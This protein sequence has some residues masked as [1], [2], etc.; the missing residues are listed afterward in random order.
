MGPNLGFGLV[1]QENTNTEKG[2]GVL[3]EAITK[4]VM[5]SWKMLLGKR[6]EAWRKLG[7][8]LGEGSTNTRG[9]D[10]ENGAELEAPLWDY[11]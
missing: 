3:R 5:L 8:V 7:E 6:G 4:L 10:L 1:D 9:V 2:T 11:Q